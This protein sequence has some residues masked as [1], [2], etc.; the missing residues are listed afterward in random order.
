MNAY[1][2]IFDGNRA[3]VGSPHGKPISLSADAKQRVQDLAK[4]YGVWY[5]GDGKDVAVNSAL[6]GPRTAY[7][8]SWDDA[9]AKAVKGYP[10][11][12]LSGMFSNVAVNGMKAD[13]LAPATTIF[14]S[15]L[16]NQEGNRYFT[17]RKFD[18]ATL[19]KFLQMV[20]DSKYDFVAMSK[21]RAT[22]ENVSKFFDAGEERMFPP[23]WDKYPY[24]AGK[25]MK[26][27]EDAR[28]QFLLDQKS[29][30]YVAGAGHLIELLRMDK[31]LR[32]V[33][34]SKAKV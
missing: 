16:K 24:P 21:K 8:G 14:E 10:P 3:F 13:T 19:T 6:F 5:E 1:G 31:S 25:V 29:G 4:R 20:S 22:K 15:I 26:K 17:D 2:V 30:V 28:N 23:N 12:Y 27:F 18:A 33:G 7:R 32:M 11:E 9:L 34:G